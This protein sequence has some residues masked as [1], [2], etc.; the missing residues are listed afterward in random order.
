MSPTGLPH[1]ESSGSKLHS[2]SPEIIAGNR[3]LHRLLMPRHPP[4]ALTSLTKNFVF[5]QTVRLFKSL[6]ISYDI[7]AYG[8]LKAALTIRHLRYPFTFF[9]LKGFLFE[10]DSSS[11][12]FCQ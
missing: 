2:S 4:A 3:V 6:V 11:V 8:P 12:D 1:S 5:V 10:D 7:I 9:K